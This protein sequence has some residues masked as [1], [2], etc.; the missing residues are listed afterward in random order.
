MSKTFTSD[1]NVVLCLSSKPPL[2]DYTGSR[3][4]IVRTLQALSTA[5]DVHLGFVGTAEVSLSNMQRALGVTGV[6]E[7]PKASNAAGLPRR[8]LSRLWTRLP[9]QL[10]G[11]DIETVTRAFADLIAEVEPDVIWVSGPWALPFLPTALP[12]ALIVD[13]QHAERSTIDRDLRSHL[14]KP[15]VQR[16]NLS[17]AI[18]LLIDR[19]PRLRIERDCLRRADLIT[20]CSN[21]DLANL[22]VPGGTPVLLIPNGVDPP[23]PSFERCP[24][25]SRLLLVGD[26]HYRPNRETA[27]VLMNQ[28]FPLIQREVPTVHVDLV[29]LCPDDLRASLESDVC[30]VHGMVLDLLPLYRQATLA[31]LP[32]YSGSG[33]R[34]KVLEACGFG[35]PV[36]TTP[37]GLEGLE[38]RPGVDVEVASQAAEL[39][40]HAVKLLLQPRE[41]EDLARCASATVAQRYE[42]SVALELLVDWARRAR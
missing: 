30:T 36:V 18:K 7:L 5:A 23:P 14:R 9:L 24:D 11:A 31:V 27:E 19:G 37:M 26:L 1:R 10:V 25:P 20:V 39:S 35:V 32:I 38:L 8:L 15:W 6:H 12:T 22:D 40:K 13:M 29:G 4:R 33:T 21:N 28:V 2:P 16:K 17:T 34:T 42:W 3:R 41:A